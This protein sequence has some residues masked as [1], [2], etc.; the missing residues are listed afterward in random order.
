MPNPAFKTNHTN[1]PMKTHVIP[2]TIAL[3]LL[4]GATASADVAAIYDKHCASCH[5]RDG[6]G[7]TNMGRMTKAKDYT[8]AEGQKWTDAEGV[9]AILEGAGKMKGYK[10]KV[11]RKEAD[12]LVGY[13][14][15]FQKKNPDR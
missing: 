13:I 10:K 12:D 8:T 5:G 7:R 3:L 11:S 6:K 2:A 15:S 4:A 14:R 1:H 9:A